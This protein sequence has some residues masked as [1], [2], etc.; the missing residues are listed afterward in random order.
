[1]AMNEQPEPAAVLVIEEFG[2]IQT[3]A[4]LGLFWKSLL[5][6]V[7]RGACTGVGF[8]GVRSPGDLE[9]FRCF[10]DWQ[11]SPVGFVTVEIE[12]NVVAAGRKAARETYAVF[13]LTEDVIERLGRTS[14]D[15]WSATSDA[16]PAD[17]LAFFNG[18]RLVVEVE[19]YEGMLLFCGSADELS[20][21]LTRL[22]PDPT[23]Y[24][25]RSRNWLVRSW[26]IAR[27]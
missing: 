5:F 16:Y 9:Q 14:F 4:E 21:S 20:S 25:S 8:S 6:E 19:P 7:I 17:R 11:P 24:L 22:R 1:M 27:I 2:A 13:E 10:S 12:R 26:K 23:P 18:N 15:A 3:K